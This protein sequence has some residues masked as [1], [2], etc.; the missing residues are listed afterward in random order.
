MKPPK[1]TKQNLPQQNILDATVPSII[2]TTIIKPLTATQLR[3]TFN[4][5]QTDKHFIANDIST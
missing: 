4:V 5:Q 2:D 3:D 1:S